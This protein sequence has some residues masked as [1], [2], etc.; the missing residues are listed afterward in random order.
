MCSF[1]ISGY[2]AQL[3]AAENSP[4]CY[5]TCLHSLSGSSSSINVKFHFMTN[6]PVYISATGN[7]KVTEKSPLLCSETNP[8]LHC[9]LEST[10]GLSRGAQEPGSRGIPLEGC[11]QELWR[12]TA[13]LSLSRWSPLMGK[14][15]LLQRFWQLKQ[16]HWF[17]IL[18]RR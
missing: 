6:T 13:L 14:T 1:V 17:K 9:G 4:T 15:R 3:K 18:N 7:Q 10:H 12:G 5:K 8:P 16:R 2:C 11:L